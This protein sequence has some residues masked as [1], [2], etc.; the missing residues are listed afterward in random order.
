[1]KV[2]DL[3]EYYAPE[4]TPHNPHDICQ[5]HVSEIFPSEGLTII[6]DTHLIIDGLHPITYGCPIRLEGVGEWINTNKCECIVDQQD[7]GVCHQSGNFKA[8]LDWAKQSFIE[9][10]F[11]P[12]GEEESKEGGLVQ[13][14][15]VRVFVGDVKQIGYK[16]DRKREEIASTREACK[17]RKANLDDRRMSPRSP[18]MERRNPIRHPR[19]NLQ[20][21]ML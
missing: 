15:L 4:G 5:G 18:R 19:K 13:N 16:Q 11:A 1:M 9:K 20:V 14:G 8:V 21:W 17:R 6:L 7:D 10:M 2:G 3:L 12:S